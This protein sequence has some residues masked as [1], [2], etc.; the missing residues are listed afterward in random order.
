MNGAEWRVGRAFLGTCLLAPGPSFNSSVLPA[1][2][3][4]EV[5]AQARWGRAAAIGLGAPR[6]CVSL[7]PAPV[8]RGPREATESGSLAA[9]V[10]A[11]QLS[12]VGCWF[13]GPCPLAFPDTSAE[14]PLPTLPL[15]LQ[16]LP[17]TLTG[18]KGSI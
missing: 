7:P 12:I 5:G 9:R 2:I 3:G 17:D 11:L 13:L 6:V 1:A 14:D 8:L 16:L 10:V 18:R 15:P 4:A